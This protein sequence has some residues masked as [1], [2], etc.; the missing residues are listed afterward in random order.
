MK[1]PICSERL[2]QHTDRC[3][4]CGYRVP[5]SIPK[6]PAAPTRRRTTPR[7]RTAPRRGCLPGL[8]RLLVLSILF[9][10]I[11]SFVQGFLTQSRVEE[12]AIIQTVPEE[13]VPSVPQI[14]TIP[15]PTAA[16]GCFAI[17]DGA[18]TFLPE[19]WD[20][21]PILTI[22]DTVDGQ[23]VT[24]L[25]SGCFRDCI[26]LTTI[27]L[28]ETLTA[29]GTEAF[30]GC[31]GLRGLFLPQGMESIGE[32]AFD[33][34]VALEAICIPATV[35]D[36]AEGA[37]DDC[38]SLRFINYDGDFESWAAL[39]DDFITPFTIAICTDGGYYHGVK[40]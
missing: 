37:F 8:L 10:L 32:N 11:L 34:C 36:I 3:P 27:I 17:A 6:Q 20:G 15:A 31:S 13:Y 7:H 28:P 2:P 38:A 30:A 26:G 16:E 21:G 4:G 39:Y 9:P 5:V 40:E 1:C 25:G 24:A 33:G 35:T 12:Q 19:L 14:E 23:T 18:V 29:I 22:P